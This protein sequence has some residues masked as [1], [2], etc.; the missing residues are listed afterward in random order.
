MLA[1]PRKRNQPKESLMQAGGGVETCRADSK[2]GRT[3]VH[4]KPSGQPGFF[5][6]DGHVDTGRLVSVVNMSR[7]LHAFFAGR[8]H[9]LAYDD[10]QVVVPWTAIA[11]MQ[12]AAPTTRM[13]PE[14]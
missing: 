13:A 12:T 4:L 14:I 5:E 3:V 1:D 7:L 2:P 6:I 8:N 11:T 10:R 9:S